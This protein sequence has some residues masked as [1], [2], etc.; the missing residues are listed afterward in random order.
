MIHNILLKQECLPVLL[1]VLEMCNLGLDKNYMNSLDFALN[2]FFMKLFCLWNIVR[3]LFGCE[4]PS[5]LL[6]K[7]RDRFTGTVAW[8]R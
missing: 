3:V 7:R 6:K 5:V 4:L 2:R 1:Y 8:F